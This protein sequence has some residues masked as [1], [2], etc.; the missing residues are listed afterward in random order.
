MILRALLAL[1]ATAALVLAACG[2]EPISKEEQVCGPR[3]CD[4]CL[5]FACDGPDAGVH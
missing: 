4:V 2:P 3:G 1:L 5:G